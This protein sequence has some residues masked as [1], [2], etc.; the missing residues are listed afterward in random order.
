MIRLRTR[1]HDGGE[2]GR[3]D[4][5]DGT[6]VRRESRR[7]P[8]AVGDLEKGQRGAHHLRRAEQRPYTVITTVIVGRDGRR[9]EGG[10]NGVRGE[11][12]KQLPWREFCTPA[13]PS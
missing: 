2:R 12:K 4:Q 3:D 11:Q 5:V 1:V 13:P 8:P 7:Y 9:G 10:T 6:K